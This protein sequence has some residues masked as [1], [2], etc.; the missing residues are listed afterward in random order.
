MLVLTPA[1]C[2]ASRAIAR[3]IE[4]KSADQIRA[5]FRLPDD[6]SEEEKLEPLTTA[7]GGEQGAASGCSVGCLWVLTAPGGEQVLSLDVR[8]VASGFFRQ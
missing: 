1:A 5:A 2:A 7:P 8:W 6:L 4:G 3:L